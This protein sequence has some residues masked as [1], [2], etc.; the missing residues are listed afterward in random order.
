MVL[1]AVNSAFV[2]CCLHIVWT[3]LCSPSAR[4]PA[5]SAAPAA[6]D[7]P[8]P[9]VAGG[10]PGYEENTPGAHI[11][12]TAVVQP[13]D[14]VGESFYCITT[15][16]V[17]SS[18]KQQAYSLRFTS[19]QPETCLILACTTAFVSIQLGPCSAHQ[20]RSLSEARRLNCTALAGVMQTAGSRSS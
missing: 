8:Q 16:G 14:E 10:G 19:L 9:G 15:E 7:D 3:R 2:A 1:F 17:I 5:P 4:E 20:R 12:M 11:G 13:N 18:P 6:A